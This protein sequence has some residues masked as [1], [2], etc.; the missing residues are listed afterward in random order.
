MGKKTKKNHL[1]RFTAVTFIWHRS[2]MAVTLIVC[3]LGAYLNEDVSA[4]SQYLSV[5]WQSAKFLLVSCLPFFLKKFKIDIPD[6]IYIIFMFY[7]VSHF[8]CGEILDFY[9][10]YKWWDSFLHLSSGMAIAL[11]S[12]S[13]INL[14]NNNTKDFKINIV[15]AMFFA[16]SMTVAAGVIWEIIE[17]VS[18]I[19]NGSNMQRAYVSTPHGRGEPF[20]GQEALKDTMK[21]LILDSSGAALM[22]IICGIA[23][24]TKKIRLE[25]LSF[26]KRHKKIEKQEPVVT[27][28]ESVVVEENVSENLPEPEN[29]E[30]KEVIESHEQEKQPEKQ[31]ATEPKKRKPRKTTAK[32][33]L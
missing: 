29:A 15:F 13:F 5:A 10:K 33:E 1:K 23:V 25:D 22:S 27:K 16:F 9:Y 30:T 26:I 21:D 8:I 18:D 7:I 4:K 31:T 19:R 32:K 2:L 11:L 17:F 28:T 3:A 14:M 12:F 20:V 6:V 24:W